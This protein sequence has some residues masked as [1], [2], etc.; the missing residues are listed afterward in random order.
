MTN[1][2]K[3]FI[4]GQWVEAKSGETFNSINPA[5]EA[6]VA[7]AYQS[8]SEDVASAVSAAKNA[9]HKWRLNPCTPTR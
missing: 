6:V 9:Y 1:L 2:V 4:A 3:N 8:N 5:T 7:T